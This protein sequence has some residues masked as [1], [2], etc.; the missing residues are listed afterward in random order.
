LGDSGVAPM[1]RGAR[2]AVEEINAN[3]GVLEPAE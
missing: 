2:L 3:G 1:L